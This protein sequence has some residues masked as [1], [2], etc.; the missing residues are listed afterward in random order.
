MK[1]PWRALRLSVLRLTLA[2]PR[3][4][5]FIAGQPRCGSSLLCKSLE[6]TG[7]LGNGREYFHPRT[8]QGES[9][10]R[11]TLETNCLTAIRRGT[12]PNGIAA[13]KVF[14][15]QFENVLPVIDLDYWF[16]RRRWVCLRR[17]DQLGQAISGAIALQTN[18]W[19][20]TTQ[21]RTGPAYSRA[22][23]EERLR[24]NANGYDQWDR[25]FAANRIEPLTLWYEDI[26]TNMHAAVTSVARL[27]G[28]EVLESEVRRTQPFVDGRFD[29]GLQKQRTALNDEWRLRFEHGN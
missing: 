20:S 19:K 1:V 2:R 7:L 29:T 28:G 23:V 17:R 18:Q 14:W 5:I 27:A 4:A 24:F 13:V 26:E 11:T 16:P 25:Y 15:S 9:R 3:I 21:A 6:L 10:T 22:L 12:S 8:Q